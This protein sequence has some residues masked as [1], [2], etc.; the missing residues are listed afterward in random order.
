MELMGR[1]SRA[2]GGEADLEEAREI[3][4]RGEMNLYMA[5]YHLEAAKEIKSQKSKCKSAEESLNEAKRLIEKC[6]YHRRDGE[7][8]LIEAELAIGDGNK[9]AAGKKVQQAKKWID[10]KGMHRWDTEVERLRLMLDA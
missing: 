1:G 5:D 9:E 8:M 3:A 10:E 4:E 2:D 7:V 6:G